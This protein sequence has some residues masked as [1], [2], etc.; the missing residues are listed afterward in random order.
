MPAHHDVGRVLKRYHL[1]ARPERGHLCGG[2]GLGVG[3]ELVE[4]DVVA[5]GDL[6]EALRPLAAGHLDEFCRG[7]ERLQEGAELVLVGGDLLDA[8]HREDVGFLG[9]KDTL[10]PETGDLLDARNLAVLCPGKGVDGP[11]RAGTDRAF[12]DVDTKDLHST[13]RASASSKAYSMPYFRLKYWRM[14]PISR[15]RISPAFGCAISTH[16]GQSISQHCFSSTM[17]LNSLKSPWMMPRR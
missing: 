17:T 11:A 13:T 4:T 3:V 6:S 7:R 15:A 2:P 1:D 9:G 10:E 5:G 8:V 12:D 16:C 14:F